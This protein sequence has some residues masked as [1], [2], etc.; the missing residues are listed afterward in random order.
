MRS[1]IEGVAF[2]LDG[3]LYPNYRLYI[4]LIPFLLKEWRLVSA[5]G[6]ARNIIRKKQ[7]NSPDLSCNPERSFYDHQAAVTAE[8]L[9]MPH[10]PLKEK[11]D[12]LIYRGWEP[13]FKTIKL[14]KGV[15]ET[16]A[17]IKNAGY[18]LGLLSDFPPEIKLE[19]LKISG[20]WD[21]VLCSE[22]CGALKPHSLSF[23]ELAA[24]MSLPPG[25]IIYVGNSHKHDVSG[26]NL[27]GMKTALIK[28]R[29]IPGSKKQPKADFTFNNYRQLYDFMIN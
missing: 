19:N 25:K 18:K 5:F 2:D 14:F 16:L 11:I 10:V 29:L 6:R 7:E 8:I 21:V 24:A 22:C 17:A 28:S 27:A 20:I 1:D 15:I 26:A 23:V 13:L 9:G 3:T 4:R 12:R